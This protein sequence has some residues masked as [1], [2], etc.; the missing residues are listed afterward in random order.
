V[1]TPDVA[2]PTSARSGKPH[3]HQQHLL[4]VGGTASSAPKV[5][6]SD[7]KRIQAWCAAHAAHI[8]WMLPESASLRKYGARIS[9]S[10]TFC[11]LRVN[12]SHGTKRVPSGILMQEYRALVNSGDLLSDA[13][14]VGARVAD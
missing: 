13:S 14:Q 3:L 12:I 11:A 1:S 9:C 6:Q 8:S 10:A 4:H 2:M 5:V 7:S